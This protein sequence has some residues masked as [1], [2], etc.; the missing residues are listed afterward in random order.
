MSEWGCVRAQPFVQ[1]PAIT[2]KKF[3]TYQGNAEYPGVVVVIAVIAG[4]WL[5]AAA[6]AI[7]LCVLAARGDA[8]R[9]TEPCRSPGRARRAPLDGASGARAS[10]VTARSHRRR[11]VR[12]GSAHLRRGTRIGR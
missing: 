10:S 5:V 7:A 8:T 3:R 1:N 9:V 4:I 6:L 11:R 12:G 2:L